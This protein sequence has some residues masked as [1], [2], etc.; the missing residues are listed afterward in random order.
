MRVERGWVPL[1]LIQRGLG[2]EAL[3]FGVDWGRDGQGIDSVIIIRGYVPRI[4]DW[5]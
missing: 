1:I 3:G 5:G 4:G 2:C